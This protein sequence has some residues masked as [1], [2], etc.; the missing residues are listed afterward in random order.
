MNQSTQKEGA[1]G[2]KKGRTHFQE[3]KRTIERG[4]TSGNIKFPKPLLREKH[5]KQ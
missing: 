1:G 5:I 4:Q 2:I 3:N